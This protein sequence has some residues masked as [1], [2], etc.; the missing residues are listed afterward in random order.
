MPTAIAQGKKPPLP[1]L[2]QDQHNDADGLTAEQL[3]LIR[4][5]ERRQA[6]QPTLSKRQ[7]TKRLFG[8]PSGW[9]T[10]LTSSPCGPRACA[11]P[12]ELQQDEV[13]RACMTFPALTGF[14]WD[15]LHPRAVCG[16]S[17]KLVK[18]IVLLVLQREASCTWPTPLGV[19]IIVLLPKSDGSSRPIGLL[20][21]MA[22]CG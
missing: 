12:V 22:G 1:P 16:L 3:E 14:G 6:P 2:S 19:C 11:S 21:W 18:W 9:L 10:R 15:A 17:T 7:T 5:S 13:L 8:A 4:L 20:P